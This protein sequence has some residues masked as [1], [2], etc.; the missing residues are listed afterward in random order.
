MGY[1]H[2]VAHLTTAGGVFEEFMGRQYDYGSGRV[3]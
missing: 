1:L 2:H 3:V